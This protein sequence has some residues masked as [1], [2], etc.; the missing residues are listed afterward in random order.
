MMRTAAYALCV[1][2]HAIALAALCACLLPS[3]AWAA[4]G[5]LSGSVTYP[6]GSPAAGVQVMIDPAERQQGVSYPVRDAISDPQ[7]SWTY[8]PLPAGTYQLVYV[9]RSSSNVNETQAV[10]HVT[11]QAGQEL[12]LTTKLSGPEGPGLATVKGSV[13]EANGLPAGSATVDLTSSTSGWSAPPVLV[14]ADGSFNAL[15]PAGSYRVE[16][17]RKL[18]PGF[19]LP[20][21]EGT[22]SLSASAT[23]AAGVTNTVR[24]TMP[25][26]PPLPTPPGT[27][28]ANTER[29]LGLLNAERARWGLPSGLTA[30]ATWSQACAAHDAYLA[31]NHLLEHPERSSL[32]GYSP[33]GNWGGMHS[34]LDEGTPWQAQAN[35]WEDAPI[36]LDQLYTP[37]LYQVGIDES[38]GYSCVTTWP[39]IGPSTSPIGTVITYPGNDTSGLPPSENAEESPFVPGKFVGVPQGTIAGRELFVYEEESPLGGGCVG[40]CFGRGPTVLAATLSSA[41]GPAQLKWVDSSGEIGGYLTGAILIP[42]KPL[43]PDTTYHASVTLA[44]DVEHGVGE[45]THAWT[46]TTG[47]ENPG[48]VWPRLATEPLLGQRSPGPYLLRLYISPSSFRPARHGPMIS[49]AASTHAPASST[50]SSRAG[51]TVGYVDDVLGTT[52]F[53]VLRAKS[54]VLRGHLCTARSTTS[55]KSKHCTLYV[56]LVSFS[57]HD[58]KGVDRF[59]FSGRVAGKALSAGAYELRATPRRGKTVGASS[60][61]HFRI[62][63]ACRARASSR[64][65]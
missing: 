16:I 35:P 47:P 1:C 43:A 59:H 19:S 41:S 12:A 3:T 46:F 32:P 34:V 30:N 8:S 51:A 5:S 65:R 57:R 6:S 24:Y 33:G 49:R 10:E 45:V 56:H 58:H 29:D 60:I 48:G 21:A 9:V 44:A 38:R 61:V 53:E 39:G 13:S 62:L 52:T 17:T 20:D 54:G 4:E 28:A 14:E 7:G 23:F 2:T 40:Y 31:E 55:T 63:S 36:H 64:C 22:E 26:L 42:P 50:S 18:S 27:T 15:M 25:A 37:D 11:L